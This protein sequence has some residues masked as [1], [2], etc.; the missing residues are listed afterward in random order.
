MAA[1]TGD[2]G[3]AAAAALVIGALYLGYAAVVCWQLRSSSQMRDE[4]VATRSWVRCTPPWHL[5]AGVLLPAMPYLADL[6]CVINGL[7]WPVELLTRAWR[8][9]EER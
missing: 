2:H 3:W 8:S 1:L 5:L 9:G 7:L 6:V 4:I